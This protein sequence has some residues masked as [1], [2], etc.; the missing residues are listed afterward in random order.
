MWGLVNRVV[1]PEDLLPSARAL[2]SDMVDCDPRTQIAM[3]ELIDRGFMETLEEGLSMERRVSEQSMRNFEPE[4]Y[5]TRR[6]NIQERG[7]R[8]AYLEEQIEE[9]S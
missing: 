6:L 1:E 5:A 8:Q 2:A 4:R 3:K 9:Q 7:L